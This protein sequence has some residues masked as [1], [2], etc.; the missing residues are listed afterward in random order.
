MPG[1]DED[2]RSLGGF[3]WSWR[4]AAWCHAF[5]NGA[6]GVGL[7]GEAAEGFGAAVGVDTGLVGG[8]GQG[9]GAGYAAHLWLPWRTM[10]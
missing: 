9:A 3:V 8:E 2:I 5:E 4:G 6:E 1:T 10:S 7:G